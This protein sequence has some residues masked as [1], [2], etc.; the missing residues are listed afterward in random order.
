[1][2]VEE[3]QDDIDLFSGDLAPDLGSPLANIIKAARLV[4]D[5][6]TIRY[7]LWHERRAAD[8]SGDEDSGAIVTRF[9]S[10][11]DGSHDCIVET[12]LLVTPQGDT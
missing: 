8:D 1:M 2:N 11:Q 6:A 4:A 5:G 9:C 3:L 12:R 7:C 10:S